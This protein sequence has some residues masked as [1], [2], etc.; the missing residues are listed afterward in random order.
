MTKFLP[1]VGQFHPDVAYVAK[2][3][4]E[5]Y[6]GAGVVRLI[7]NGA[8]VTGA[9]YID[10]VFIREACAEFPNDPLASASGGECVVMHGTA[11]AALLNLTRKANVDS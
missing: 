10:H 8:M 4:P 11:A 2:F 3:S 5:E 9:E 1:N 7:L 6:H